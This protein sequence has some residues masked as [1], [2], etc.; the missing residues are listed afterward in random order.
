M[1]AL[2]LVRRISIE[3]YKEATLKVRVG[4]TAV[5]EV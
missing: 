1:T 3:L 4:T 5:T 2:I